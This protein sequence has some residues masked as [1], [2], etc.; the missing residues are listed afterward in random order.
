M[1]VEEFF[2]ALQVSRDSP[3]HTYTFRFKHNRRREQHHCAIIW[4]K[5]SPGSGNRARR[6]RDGAGG[7]GRGGIHTAA[8]IKIDRV[9][10]RKMYNR[11]KRKPVQS[12]ALTL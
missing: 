7:G 3:K 10:E 9:E 5:R 4:S 12:Q 6:Q 1:C 2:S 11:K 8:E